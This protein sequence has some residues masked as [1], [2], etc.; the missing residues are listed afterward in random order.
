MAFSRPRTSVSPLGRHPRA[1]RGSVT[2]SAAQ[3]LTVPISLV[4]IPVRSVQ[5]CQ[6]EATHV[7]R[8]DLRSL[9]TR[10]EER[11]ADVCWT[12]A[13]LRSDDADDDNDRFDHDDLLSDTNSFT[14]SIGGPSRSLIP[15]LNSPDRRSS[16]ASSAIGSDQH[17]I[18]WAHKA[19]LYARAPNTFQARY[20]QLRSPA[21]QLGHLESNASLVSLPSLRSA[22]AQ[23][24]STTPIQDRPGASDLAPA[25]KTVRG[26]APPSSFSMRRPQNDRPSSRSSS[27]PSVI[28]NKGSNRNIKAESS[29]AYMT[30]DSEAETPSLPT[31]L[32][33]SPSFSSDFG[34]IASDAVSVISEAST[35]RAPMSL[36]GVSQAFFEATLEYL[37]TGE[38]SMIDA[39]EFLYEDRVY[40]DAERGPGEK[41]EKLRSDLTYMWR[42]KLYSD[43]KIILDNGE[44]RSPSAL[45][46]DDTLIASDGRSLGGLRPNN[47]LNLPNIPDAAASVLSLPQTVDTERMDESDAEDDELT[48]FSSHRMILASRSPYFASMLLNPYAD[49][50]SP[51]LTLPSPPFTPAA[52]HF[53]L[54]F[55]YTGTLFF[56]NRTFDLTTAFQLWRAGAYLQVESLQNLVVAIIAQDFCHK[57]ACS[58]PCRKCLRRVPRA[59][60]FATSPDVCD[61]SL[62]SMA[63]EP[64][65]GPDFGAFW[66]KEVGNLNS[67]L[68]N[69]LVNIVCEKVER[70]PALFTSVLCQLSIVGRRVD[71]E[72][73]TKW[74]EALRA[75]SETIESRL[76]LVLREHFAQI[77]ESQDWTN[78]LTGTTAY[79]D[80]LEKG[81][82][83]LVDGLTER[84]AATT[85]QILVGQ[86][87]LR[88]DGIELASARQAVED[89]RAGILRYL[90]KRWINVRTLSGFNKLE[91]WC[92]KEIADEMDVASTDLVMPDQPQAPE[93]PKTRT[94]L[95]PA[96]GV[97]SSAGVAANAR[98]TVGK[99]AVQRRT[100]SAG[101]TAGPERMAAPRRSM[102]PITPGRL[103]GVG[104]AEGSSSSASPQATS[105]PA[106]AVAGKADADAERELGPIDLRASVLNRNA[107]RTSVVHGHRST[108]ET[109]RTETTPK[110]RRATGPGPTISPASPSRSV[111]PAEP[112]TSP[113]R[114]RTTSTASSTLSIRSRTAST[115]QPSIPASSAVASTTTTATPSTTGNATRQKLTSR[116]S[117]GSMRSVKSTASGVVPKATVPST[118]RQAQKAPETSRQPSQ[119]S[120]GAQA[121]AMKSSQASPS[122]AKTPSAKQ[123]L[124]PTKSTTALRPG[125]AK[126]VKT[127]VG[128]RPASSLSHNTPAAS[129]A[130]SVKADLGEA[131]TPVKHTYLRA[132]PGPGG[133]FSLSATTSGKDLRARTI[134]GNST[135]SSR[136]NASMSLVIKRQASAANP[137]GSDA[138]VSRS[139]TP[140]QA[141]AR[142]M[143]STSSLAP[144]RKSTE[145]KVSVAAVPVPGSPETPVIEVQPASTD[146]EPCRSAPDSDAGD[147]TLVAAQQGTE[148]ESVSAPSTV[149][150]LGGTSL[151]QGIPCIVSPQTS[152]GARK[153]VG[154]FKATV[155]YI[156]PILCASGAWVGIEIP[157][158]LPRALDDLDSPGGV[159]DGSLDGVQYYKLA[160]ESRGLFI[161]PSDVLWVV[162]SD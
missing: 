22:P 32:H 84:T 3:D 106:L 100:V 21:A 74:V 71:T 33:R 2:T 98:S 19:I 20:L 77:I 115:R 99:P 55:L 51:V 56:S 109:V 91:K 147:T 87:L 88:E 75:M 5:A 28:R 93:L 128:Q 102:G 9:V 62:A 43:V 151:S 119:S 52:L 113:S 135:S 10:A 144:S 54:G 17:T 44:N 156:G 153:M 7:W 29:S 97:G 42:S 104:A 13:P 136:H 14:G 11:F 105:G 85:Y 158:P 63:M 45:N 50:R 27:R 117:V 76:L 31:F 73:A 72:R 58:P 103:G 116:A 160:E 110:A 48:S 80:V 38:E 81:L 6:E 138:L 126:E 107:A 66:G 131:R 36:H 127:P 90:K 150:A 123:P 41:L 53:A 59:L 12:T 162:S 159:H 155:K 68:R 140:S 137:G 95:R 37:Y 49:S 35:I 40:T 86:V 134:S 1:T 24:R 64:L 94:G 114:V 23:S 142:R 60:A 145:T 78:L 46:G 4:T 101:E 82:V 16:R 129:P 120:N 65:S 47:D 57:F 124:R 89:A 125:Q 154:R 146:D 30:S 133:V 132:T 15:D 8:A 130:A 157:L 118:S 148:P 69:S 111:V 161:R 121:V 61:G 141:S 25:R 96:V 26:S 79:G 39:F 70:R 108:L 34:S 67:S 112:A 122:P 139:R 149:A 152:T 83:M 143:A 18:I 92:L